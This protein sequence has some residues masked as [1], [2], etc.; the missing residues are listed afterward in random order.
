MKATKK[1]RAAG[2]KMDSPKE[3]TKDWEADEKTKPMSYTAKDNVGPEAEKLK[4][5]GRAKRK[6]GGMVH[7]L[8]KV[9]GRKPNVHAGKKPRASGGRTGSN[10]N[11][12]SSAHKGTEAKSHSDA[13]EVD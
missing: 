9:H 1:H 2:G 7:H 6:H 12:L 11:P 4:R 3:G 8:G 5:G 13:V 10:F